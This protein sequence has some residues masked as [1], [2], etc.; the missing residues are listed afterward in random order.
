MRP[1]RGGRRIGRRP[2]AR[3]R[4]GAV[5]RPVAPAVVPRPGP[6][7]PLERRGRHVGAGDGATHH[8]RHERPAGDPRRG[9]RRRPCR[10]GRAGR[11]GR[12]RELRRALGDHRSRR[13]TTARPWR[14]CR[15]PSPRIPASPR[16]SA[17]TSTTASA[18]STPGR[19]TTSP[20]GCSARRSPPWRRR[21]RRCGRMLSHVDG[22]AAARMDR[23][24]DQPNVEVEVDLAK[25][26]RYGL[27]PGDVRRGAATMLAGLEVGSLFEQQKVFQVTVWSTPASRASLTGIKN[28][29]IDTPSG[30]HVRL[31]DVADVR[32]APTPTVIQR[33]AVSRRIE[34]GVDVS[35][36]DPG[37]VAAE[38]NRP[39]PGHE[40]P[41][42]VPR[43]GDRRLQ[44][45][46]D[47][48]PQDVRRR[49]R[50]RDRHPAP[51]PGCVPELAAGRARVPHA[52]RSRC[53]AACWRRSSPRTGC[54]SGRSRRS[55][56]CWRSQRA[57]SSP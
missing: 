35:G 31:E 2:G 42:R 10:P 47:P 28:V 20:S 6:R 14:R 8:A 16:A 11:P 17:R 46:R 3:S 50:R 1:V 22:V 26:K 29:V 49:P 23:R 18:T 5:V 24:V 52:S 48:A 43:R 53:P 19:R 27:K 51:A 21:R 41:A 13:P 25:A 9:Q 40:L 38:I 54:R 56:R 44:E 32:I 33:D 55:L 36:R 34:I 30:G 4:G 15:T 57:G 45:R 37:T 12:R 39:P 7:R